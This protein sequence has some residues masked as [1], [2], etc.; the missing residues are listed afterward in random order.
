[1]IIRE[2]EHSDGQSLMELLESID[3]ES[4]FMLYEKNERALSPEQSEAMIFC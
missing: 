4:T 1:M 2:V 3:G